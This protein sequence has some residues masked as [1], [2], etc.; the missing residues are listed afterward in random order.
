I[1]LWNHKTGEALESELQTSHRANINGVFILDNDKHLMSIDECGVIVVTDRA[2]KRPQIDTLLDL[3][4]YPMIMVGQMG[5]PYAMRLLHMSHLC[6]WG[7]YSLGHYELYQ[8]GLRNLPPMNSLIINPDGHEEEGESDD[9]QHPEQD[10]V[11]NAAEPLVNNVGLTANMTDEE[12]WQDDARRALAQ[13]E[14]TQD[15]LER[16][17]LEISGDRTS[18]NP[19]GERARRRQMNRVPAVDQYHII[20]I[21]PPVDPEPT[22]L[23]LSVDCRHALYL[24]RNFLTVKVV[25]KV[26]ELDELPPGEVDVDGI[27]NSMQAMGFNPIDRQPPAHGPSELLQVIAQREAEEE[28]KKIAKRKAN[29]GA[30][31]IARAGSLEVGAL[32]DEVEEEEDDLVNDLLD[33]NA[34]DREGNYMEAMVRNLRIGTWYKVVK[35]LVGEKMGR[36]N[37]RRIE[38]ALIRFTMGLSIEQTMP[39]FASIPGHKDSLLIARRFMRENAA[40]LLSEIDAGDLNITQLL[41]AVPFYAQR[42][43]ESKF[44]TAVV[45][46][47]HRGQVTT[48][49][50]V[51]RDM[52]RVYR[53]AKLPDGRVPWSKNSG[54]VSKATCF[55]QHRVSAMDDGAVAVACE[56]GYVVVLSFD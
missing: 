51:F 18:E 34:D 22:G 10:S 29:D 2:A 56:N 1:S 44:R 32:V 6:V 46:V 43:H 47:D 38:M 25:D 40:E 26:D 48:A 45:N 30:G 53:A 21:D 39:G 14:A 3:P 55:L 28:F 16:M 15:D 4:L 9:D 11:T 17:Y 33:D 35:Y 23:V 24:H 50:Q 5:A 36:L 37:L 49:A 7:K 8:P 42:L 31:S 27:R 19:E 20:N 13:L 52:E 12:R 41:T 54:F